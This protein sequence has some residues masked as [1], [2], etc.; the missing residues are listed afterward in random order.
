MRD[1]G[2]RL[3]QVL[4]L[5]VALAV[6]TSA[7]A[8]DTYVD[9]SDGDDASDTNNCRHKAT[10]CA[11]LTHGLE[12]AGSGDAVFVGGDP[13]SFN[14]PQTLT[15]GQSI[16]HKNFSTSS[17]VDTSGKT[18]V[19]TGSNGNP[20]IKVTGD[21]GR[22]DGLTIRSQTLPLQ[23]GA[24]VTVKDDRF[25]E[26]AQIDNDVVV[27]GDSSPKLTNDTFIDP[28]PLTGS[29]KDQI[30]VS[31]QSSGSPVVSKSDFEDFQIAVIAFGG[32]DPVIEKNDISG[33][34]VAE[35]A[36]AGIDVYGA[37][38]DAQI[39]DNR[40]HNP[41]HA[42]G[43]TLNG[44]IVQLD[45]AV[46][47]SRN[48]I[49]GYTTGI[50]LD[51]SHGITKLYSNVIETKTSTTGLS[52]KDTA[53]TGPG[54]ARVMSATIWGDGL[55]VSVNS[56]ALTLD[57]S[58]VGGDEGIDP[59]G[60]ASCSIEFSRGPQGASGPAGCD[61]FATTK[62][63]KLKSDDYHLKSSSPMIDKGNP[64]N[65]IKNFKDIDG[66]NREVD[67]TGN[68]KGKERRDIGADE[69]KC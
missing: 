38:E 34:H 58:I 55:A 18:I 65:A 29:G 27:I 21:A 2:A 28:T 54:D 57:S 68:C 31:L 16:V 35:T 9:R 23:I 14:A 11:T 51:D 33:T 64:D 53:G 1:S 25:D 63:P 36:G 24:K 8:Q 10:P 62:N 42:G 49:E 56:A 44:V 50:G 46:S 39:D 48:R 41:S 67:G 19:D 7:L 61:E 60:S 5:A 32:G 15:D 17:S 59:N 13:V 4:A 40:L 3:V 45:A 26:D 66:D 52:L 37:G 30:A 47:L 69:F 22:I 20:A 12:E 6:P 43:D